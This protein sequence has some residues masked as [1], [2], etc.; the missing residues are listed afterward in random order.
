M[1]KW[2]YQQVEPSS[3]IDPGMTAVD[4]LNDLGDDGWELVYVTKK[5]PG[6]SPE[7]VWTLKRER[8]PGSRKPDRRVG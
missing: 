5:H 2:E 8:D 7:E 6:A 4:V 3:L 1:K